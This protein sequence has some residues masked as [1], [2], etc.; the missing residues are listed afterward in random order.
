MC[1]GGQ[2]RDEQ[3]TPTQANRQAQPKSRAIP[4]SFQHHF[5]NL[6]GA[7]LDFVTDSPDSALIRR[8]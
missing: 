8:L 3:R 5:L 2:R 4:Q 7:L 6:G 1:R